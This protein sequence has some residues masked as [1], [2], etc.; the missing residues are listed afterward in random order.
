MKIVVA[1]GAGY[2]GSVLVPH[3][4]S[5]KHEVK[6]IDALW[7]GNY[8]PKDVQ[9]VKK[10]IFETTVDDLKGYDQVIFIAGVSNDPMAEFSP[11]SNFVNNVA[12]PLYLAYTA[13]LAEIRRFIF[14]SSCSVYGYS[15][16][17][18]FDEDSHPTCGYPYGLSKIQAE[19]GLMQLCDNNF[20]VIC[21][22]KGTICGASD[23]MRFDLVINTMYKSAM[24]TG[25]ITVNNP[26]LW[27]P[28]FDIRDA[29]RAYAAAVESDYKID[30]IFNVASD[31]F[32]LDKLGETVRDEI[33]KLTGKKIIL[34]IKNVHDLR[35]YR[36]DFEKARK[37][38][39]F[40]PKFGVKDIVDSLY[41]KFKDFSAKDF[42]K[43]EYYNIAIFKKLKI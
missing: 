23:R 26:S 30:G 19:K 42:E 6:V 25:K 11:A 1:G 37:I 12:L 35:S 32:R 18:T 16:C 22:R 15:L 14:A 5:L 4:I 33:E 7:F 40:V 41:N 17:K 24:T 20:S 34:E 36:V 43:E 2:V 13:K 3:L 9:V 28:L 21:L 39:D 8:L 38:L 29:V 10:N 27:R 31:N